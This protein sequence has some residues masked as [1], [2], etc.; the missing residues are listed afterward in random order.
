MLSRP[1]PRESTTFSRAHPHPSTKV[2][3]SALRSL[4]AAQYP[5][6]IPFQS[7]A[8]ETT[9]R[10]TTMIFFSLFDD[11][12][13]SG[14]PAPIREGAQRFYPEAPRWGG[15]SSSKPSSPLLSLEHA[16]ISSL[17]R[18]HRRPSPPSLP[19]TLLGASSQCPG[20]VPH[21]LAKGTV[22]SLKGRV[23][24][25]PS[26][27]LLGCEWWALLAGSAHERMNARS[28]RVWARPGVGR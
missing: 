1:D 26:A 21:W 5:E 27:W 25:L 15:F 12:T 7:L 19:R 10:I 16:A 8:T 22:G 18:T 2:K 4:L 13:F 24:L 11:H 20:L 23:P 9:S 14:T 6:R 3:V 17:P 28:C